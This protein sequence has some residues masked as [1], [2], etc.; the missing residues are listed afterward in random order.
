M[1]HIMFTSFYSWQPEVIGS[2]NT[3]ALYHALDRFGVLL[4]KE[5]N[6]PKLWT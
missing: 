4:H 1:D 5:A 3:F 2:D 6:G